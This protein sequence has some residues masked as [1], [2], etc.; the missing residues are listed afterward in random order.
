M[1]TL[2]RLFALL[3]FLLSIPAFAEFK[4]I[5][6]EGTYNMG[7]GETPAVA[8]SRALL[9]AKRVAVEQAGTYIES[10]S[11]VKNFQLTHDEIQVLASGIIEVTILDKKRTVVGDGI[12]FWVKIKARVQ[13]DRIEEMAKKVKEKSTVEDYKRLQE[14]YDDLSRQI[15]ILKNQLKEA[16]SAESKMQIEAKIIEQEKIFKANEWLERGN[17][18]ENYH[19]KIEA[20]TRAIALN[21][22]LKEAYSYRA[23]AFIFLGQKDKAIEDLTKVIALDPNDEYAFQ[24]RGDAYIDL[25]NIEMGFGDYDR[26]VSMD[27]LNPLK[28]VLRGL[29]YSMNKFPQKAIQDFQKAIELKP[30]D[31]DIRKTL[32]DEYIQTGQ[33]ERAIETCNMGIRISSDCYSCFVSRGEAYALK[34]D[35]GKALSDF[36]KAIVMNPEGIGV[37]EKRGEAYLRNGLLDKAR[38]N[39]DQAINNILIRQKQF[40]GAMATK[41]KYPEFFH[42]T[43]L[44]LSSDL[45]FAH[46]DRADIYLSK[47]EYDKAIQD[48]NQAISLAPNYQPAYLGRAWSFHG[49]G[50]KRQDKMQ[51]NQAIRDYDRAIEL[52]PKQAITYLNRGIAYNFLGDYRQALRDYK[53]A[54]KLGNGDAQ[55]YLIEIGE[56]W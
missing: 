30:T 34:G 22:N 42:Y 18:E 29:R 36:E 40:S 1:K 44:P 12:N 50:K 32:A 6:S 41:F 49:L 35:L 5:I 17:K 19:D 43:Y 52:D 4:E 11:K 15:V 16:M 21:P 20:Y 14:N 56:S 10:Y 9:Q 2:G 53:T 26:W 13:Q 39:Y 24:N 33:Y 3:L 27:P 54:A 37:Y 31:V 23:Y 28:Y 7:D 55:K 47:K 8:E 46:M 48:F 51:I 45:L 25:G 38:E